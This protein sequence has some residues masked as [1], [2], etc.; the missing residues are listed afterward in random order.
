MI[1]D[2]EVCPLRRIGPDESCVLHMLRADAPHFAGF[3][4]MYFS[5][6]APGI[7]KGWNRHRRMTIALAVPAGR[8]RV[9][10]LDDREDSQ[11]RGQS[12][13]VVL[14]D[15]FSDP[16]PGDSGTYSLLVIPPGLWVGYRGEGDG[17]SLM[18]NCANMP[19]DPAELDKRPLE[20]PPL[21]DRIP[22][23]FLSASF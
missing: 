4:E 8:V 18:A 1:G 23:G 15:P 9:L 22:S 14:Q 21:A 7:V 19:H 11:S 6:F 12:M 2:V 3:G 10:I 17:L 5:R 13:Q 16:A 20:A